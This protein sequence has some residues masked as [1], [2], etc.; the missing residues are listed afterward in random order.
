MMPS[1]VIK[2]RPSYC[3]HPAAPL[4]RPR[5]AGVLYEAS[6][7]HEIGAFLFGPASDGAPPLPPATSVRVQTVCNMIQFCA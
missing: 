3:L 6:S 4:G 5:A 7:W 2:S 1:L